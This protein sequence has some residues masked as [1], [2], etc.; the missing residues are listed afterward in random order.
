MILQ[1]VFK[2]VMDLPSGY[3]V[4]HRCAA[5]YVPQRVPQIHQL[6]AHCIKNSYNGL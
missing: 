3:D 4:V 1:L 5:V 6:P 2:I